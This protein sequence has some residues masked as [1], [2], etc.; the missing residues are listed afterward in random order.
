MNTFWIWKWRKLRV[1]RDL[2]KIQAM[3]RPFQ[4]FQSGDPSGDPSESSASTRYDAETSARED[5]ASRLTYLDTD[6]SGTSPPC[7]APWG[8]GWSLCNRHTYAY[9]YLIC[10]H[11][12]NGYACMCAG[13]SLCASVCLHAWM[14]G[15]TQLDGSAHFKKR[16]VLSSLITKQRAFGTAG[17][18]TCHS[19][20]P[21]ALRL[22]TQGVTG[23]S[24]CQS[25]NLLRHWTSAWVSW[26]QHVYCAA[27]FLRS[28]L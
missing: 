17:K 9:K 18:F 14:E 6:N 23:C 19:A 4:R 24:H 22:G 16:R 21:S 28:Q 27:T 2:C 25:G 12:M 1:W 8:V 13:M 5:G 26:G 7:A 11:D 20:K 10:M 3:P 15:Q